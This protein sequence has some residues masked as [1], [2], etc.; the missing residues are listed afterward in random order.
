M[1]NSPKDQ[2]QYGEVQLSRDDLNSVVTAKRSRLQC[3]M[4]YK[5]QIQKLREEENVLLR[6]IDKK[7]RMQ[8][9]IKKQQS[10]INMLRKLAGEEEDDAF[11]TPMEV[12]EISTRENERTSEVSRKVFFAL[13]AVN[14]QG[15]FCKKASIVDKDNKAVYDVNVIVTVK[16]VKQSKSGVKPINMNLTIKNNKIDGKISF[17]DDKDQVIPC[18]LEKVIGKFKQSDTRIDKEN[19]PKTVKPKI[20]SDVR[21]CLPKIDSKYKYSRR[22]DKDNKNTQQREQVASEKC[23]TE[24]KSDEK[25]LK[26]EIVQLKELLAHAKR[27][28]DTLSQKDNLDDSD[29]FEKGLPRYKKSRRSPLAGVLK[30]EVPGYLSPM[31]PADQT[32]MDEDVEVPMETQQ[33]DEP[34]F[35]GDTPDQPSEADQ[36]ATQ[37][38]DEENVIDD[39]TDQPSTKEDDDGKSNDDREDQKQSPPVSLKYQI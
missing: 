8:G 24:T 18:S 23:A 25:R 16:S 30:P 26:E 33:P 32:G 4:D 2:I 15:T 31:I 21:I 14:T 17:V 29:D 39:E 7:I 1:E 38:D 28:G 27:S 3:E 20:T 13:Q 34:G 37:R 5:S 22:S 6:R 12:E 11:P 19:Q 10:R 9:I 35:S 36:P